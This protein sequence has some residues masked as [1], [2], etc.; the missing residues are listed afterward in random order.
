M[1]KEN[2]K[3]NNEDTFVSRRELL[4]QIGGFSIVAA[5][6]MLGG[7]AMAEAARKA[8]VVPLDDSLHVIPLS[9]RPIYPT[10]V[11]EDFETGDFGKY[12]WVHGG[13]A[14]WVIVSDQKCGGMYSAKSG[15]ISHNQ[16][17]TLEISL[18]VTMGTVSF[19][20]RVSS[21][22]SYD[23]LQ[24]YIDDTL[25]SAWSGEVQWSREEFPVTA[26]RHSFKWR[27]Y[28][29]GSV[30]SGSDCAYLDKI[31]ITSDPQ[32]GDWCDYSDWTDYSVWTDWTDWTDDYS[33][34]GRWQDW[35]NY[36][37]WGAWS[38]WAV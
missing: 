22:L 26:G 1:P 15:E 3:N 16:E 13:D 12:P 4:K 27:Y 29:D 25:M 14:H 23:Y 31:V 30:D 11:D 9:D 35:D 6:V 33:V 32:Y 36:Y 34:Y 24:F 7:A 19:H 17:S 38:N 8:F 18:D 2:E 10:P 37:V 5:G 20:K 28:K 21:E